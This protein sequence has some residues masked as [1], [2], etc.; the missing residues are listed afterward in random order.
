MRLRLDTGQVMRAIGATI[1][2][3]HARK[4]NSG[5]NFLRQH[6]FQ[7]ATGNQ[8]LHVGRT[9]DQNAF[10][11][12][13]REGGPAAPHLERI[14]LAPGVEVTAKLDIPMRNTRSV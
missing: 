2:R 3:A 11:K 10:H 4:C 12:H 6:F 14:A 13:H 1:P 9:T 8:S 5:Q 7:F